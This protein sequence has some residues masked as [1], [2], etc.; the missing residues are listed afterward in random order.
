MLD[1]K[2]EDMNGLEEWHLLCNIVVSIKLFGWV[3]SISEIKEYLFF[4]HADLIGSGNKTVK[5]QS[6]FLLSWSFHF[7]GGTRSLQNVFITVE[8]STY[9]VSINRNYKCLK[10][11]GWEAPISEV[12][13]KWVWNSRTLWSSIYVLCLL[14]SVESFSQKISLIREIRT[15][16]NKGKQSR[17]TVQGN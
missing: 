14:L 13:Q 11:C 6:L 7:N 16:R 15:C 8:I 4:Y 10:S 2:K 5:Q 17:E 1:S 12:G 9:S 3:L